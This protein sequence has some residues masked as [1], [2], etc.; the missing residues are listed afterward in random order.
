MSATN[1]IE[2]TAEGGN[3]TIDA[4][5]T[6]YNQGKFVVKAVDSLLAQ[7]LPPNTIWVIDDG[8]TDPD[9]LAAL[10]SLDAL[11]GVRVI[12]QENSGVST[13]RNAGLNVS[14]ADFVVMLDGDDT[15][16]LTFI[17]ATFAAL[18]ANPQAKAAS[19]WLKMFGI[20]HASVRP[21]G[22]QITNFLSANSS[23]ACV[24]LRMSEVGS[25]L[26]YDESMRNGFEDWGFFLSLLSSGGSI[27]IVRQEL[28]NYRTAP[29][30]ANITSMAKRNALYEF[31]V[32]KHAAIFSQHWRSTLLESEARST[33]RLLDWE[34][35]AQAHDDIDLGTASY[36]DGGMA[37]VVRLASARR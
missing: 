4:V 33:Q 2:T 34:R 19:S 6:S 12:R 26:R 11:D 3:P 29:L 35:L 7:T 30:S 32:D 22:G 15:L 23:P 36:G 37:S 24:M 10:A 31:L 17:E 27:D 9:S 1:T 13:A 14:E 21:R 20:A 16:A 28:I 5:V 18:E 25:D 8:S